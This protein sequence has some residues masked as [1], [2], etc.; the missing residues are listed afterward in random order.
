MWSW[1]CGCA[2]FRVPNGSRVESQCCPEEAGEEG[3]VRRPDDGTG[4]ARPEQPVQLA[5]VVTRDLRK[6]VVF[7]MIVLVEQAEGDDSRRLHG[8]AGEE[9]VMRVGDAV[10]RE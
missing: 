7:Q 3:E 10:L 9:W 1:G 2:R 5:E 8:A 6:Q 4:Q